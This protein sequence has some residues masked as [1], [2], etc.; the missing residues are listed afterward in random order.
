MGFEDFVAAIKKSGIFVIL[1]LV[2]ILGQVKAR[3]AELEL[4]RI[5]AIDLDRDVTALRLADLNGDGTNEIFVGLW[6]GDSA[7]IEVFSGFNGILIERS[8]KICTHKASDL[9]VGDIDGDKYLEV[10]VVSG[11]LVSVLDAPELSLSW[12]TTIDGNSLISVEVNDINNDDTAEVFIGTYVVFSDGGYDDGVS[13]WE[14]YYFGAL[15]YLQPKFNASGTILKC[16]DSSLAYQRLMAHDINQDSFNEIVCGAIYADEWG[17]DMHPGPE[18]VNGYRKTEIK[19]IDK[20]GS[21]SKLSTP[22]NGGAWYW[23]GPSLKSMAIGDCDSDDNLEIVTYMDFGPTDYDPTYGPSN[24]VYVLA[25]TDASSGIVENSTFSLEVDA[26]PAL[27]DVD[28]Q[29]P[30]EILVFYNSGDWWY[31]YHGTILA[32]DGT[33]FDTVA[34]TDLP[35]RRIYLFA[36]GDVGGDVLPEICITDG[37]SLFLFGFG[38]TDIEEEKEENLA[39]KFILQQNF[40]NPFNAQTT[41]RYYLPQNCEVELAIYNIKGQKVRTLVDDFQTA[42]FQSV[43]WDGTDNNG[44]EVASGIYFYRMKTDYSQETRKMVLLK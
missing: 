22:Y 31:G 6:D 8:E 33:S 38:P 36:F 41:I 14:V 35:L 10:V 28:G 26:A 40:P 5:W 15:Y 32:I 34:V 29:P 24:Y 13:W 39:P 23:W 27:Y 43:N 11:P 17:Y 9:D 1:C 7:Y 16:L 12:D 44:V 37:D 30:D 3:P 2:S 42:G 4:H 18:Y 21:L 25:I 19:V 20:N